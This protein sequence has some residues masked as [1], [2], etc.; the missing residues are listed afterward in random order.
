MNR[1]RSAGSALPVASGGADGKKII[2]VLA[3]DGGGARGIIPAMVL[4]KI[5][6]EV[7]QPIHQLFDVIAGTSTGSL[8][9]AMLTVPP[10]GND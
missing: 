10:P 9:S 5:E 6:A 3:I 8:I 2:K 1:V 4:A 7:G